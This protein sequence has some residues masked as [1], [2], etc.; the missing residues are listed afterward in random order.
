MAKESAAGGS[1]AAERAALREARLLIEEF[2]AEYCHVL[3][4]ND[5]EA[6]PRFFAE[7]AI[8]RITARENFEA[9]LPVGLVYCEGLAM[10]K[11]RAFAIARTAMFAPRY[12]QHHVS[13]T[14][15]TGIAPDGAISAES[16]YLVLQTLVDEDTTLHQA[17][18]YLDRFV[19]R[20]DGLLLRERHCV[21]DTLRIDNSLV[22]PV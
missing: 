14:R 1:A 6:W 13:N 17:G 15:I 5:I 20:G 8:Y 10:I 7:D 3:D 2:H 21:Y 4:S 19:R 16:N 18:R 9:D 12:L 22:Y 11:D